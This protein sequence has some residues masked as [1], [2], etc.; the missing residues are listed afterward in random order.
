LKSFIVASLR[1]LFAKQSNDFVSLDSYL[2]LKAKYYMDNVEFFEKE[3]CDK[4]VIL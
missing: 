4:K 2:S 1:K 3:L